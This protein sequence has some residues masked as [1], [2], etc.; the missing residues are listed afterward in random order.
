MDRKQLYHKEYN[1]KHREK[2]RARLSRPTRCEACQCFIQEWNLKRHFT[3]KKH[4]AST[5]TKLDKLQKAED[6]LAKLQMTVE[7]LKT[8]HTM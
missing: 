5:E 3:S 6:Q 8:E 4:N 7:A 2:Y 1:E